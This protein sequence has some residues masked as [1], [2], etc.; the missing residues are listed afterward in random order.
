[1]PRRH[2]NSY[3]C[4]TKYTPQQDAQ[5]TPA[6]PHP[7]LPI[8]PLVIAP[9]RRY[10][11]GQCKRTQQN[12]M[13]RKREIVQLYRRRESPV[14]QSV[15]MAYL[16][17]EEERSIRDEVGDEAEDVDGGEVDGGSR[18]RA[19]APVEEWLWVEREGPAESID[20]AKEIG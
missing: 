12:S 9:Y 11:L 15:F 5:Y 18:G 13:C 10:E 16:G 8:R 6:R 7:Q 2:D 19:T 17:G 1:M 3:R 4:H 20:P 14:P